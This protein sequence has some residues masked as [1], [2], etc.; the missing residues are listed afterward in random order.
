MSLVHAC[1][2]RKDLRKR[3]ET[4]RNLYIATDRDKGRLDIEAREED[5]RAGGF[6]AAD[7]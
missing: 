5:H 1:Q 3:S 7:E 4:K 6:E 2:N